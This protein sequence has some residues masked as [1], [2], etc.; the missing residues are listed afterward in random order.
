MPRLTQTLEERFWAKVNK[1][2]PLWNGTPCWV[3]TGAKKPN[4]YGNFGISGRVVYA[5]R[6]AYEILV[7]VIPAGFEADHLCR[8][9]ACVNPEHLDSV[10][11]KVNVLRGQSP[12]AMHAQATH[13]PQGHPYDLLNTAIRRSGRRR[14]RACDRIAHTPREKMQRE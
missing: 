6:F 2:G 13:C 8:N 7:G 1:D 12:T 9:R 10:T 5:H 11:H 3:W 14:C 4:G